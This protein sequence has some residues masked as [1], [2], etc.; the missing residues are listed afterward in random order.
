[1]KEEMLETAREHVRQN[2]SKYMAMARAG[3]PEEQSTE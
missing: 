3:E 2:K 1:M